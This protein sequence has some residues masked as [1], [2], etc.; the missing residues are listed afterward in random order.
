MIKRKRKKERKKERS[1]TLFGNSEQ[2]P[3]FFFF[4]L[5]EIFLSGSEPYFF[6]PFFNKTFLFLLQMTKEYV[7]NSP[8]QMSARNKMTTPIFGNK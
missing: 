8:P 2:N 5:I 1:Q 4:F 6:A 3:A 7:F